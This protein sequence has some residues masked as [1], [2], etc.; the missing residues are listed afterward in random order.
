VNVVRELVKA[1]HPNSVQDVAALLQF[2]IYAICFCK[3]TDGASCTIG[4]A[5]AYVAFWVGDPQH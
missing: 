1:R 4:N 5:T 2:A 3:S